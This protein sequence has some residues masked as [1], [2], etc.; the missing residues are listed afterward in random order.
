MAFHDYRK[1][2]RE[3]DGG[4]DA[5]V[6]MAVEDILSDGANLLERHG[7]VAVVRPAPVFAEAT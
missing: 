3:H 5:G 6:T 1:S 2:P 4:W 7:T